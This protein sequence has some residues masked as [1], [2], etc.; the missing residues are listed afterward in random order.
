MKKWF[1]A[2]LIWVFSISLTSYAQNQVGA[3]TVHS[4]YSTINDI[5]IDD[6]TIYAATLGGLF[7]VNGGEVLNTY[8]TI[9]GMSRLDPSKL[10]L[11]EL[12]GEVILAYTDGTLNVFDTNSQTFTSIEDIQR[13]QEFNLKKINDL[14]TIGRQLFVATDFGIVVFGLDNYLVRNS[15]LKLGSFSR[16]V[17]INAIDI[18]SDSIYCATSSGVAIASLNDNLVEEDAWLNFENVTGIPGAMI[19][20]IVRFNNQIYAISDGN[21]YVLNNGIWQ[22][23][24]EFGSGEIIGFEKGIDELA[25]FLTDKVIL[26]DLNGN[27]AEI[28][29][30]TGSTLRSFE[31]KEETLH[32]G[33]LYNGIYELD[34]SNGNVNGQLLPEGPFIN[35]FSN[36][37]FSD[38]QLI[39]STSEAF[40]SLGDPFTRLRSYSILENEKW[41]NFNRQNSSE[42]INFWDAYTVTQTESDFFIGSWGKGIVRHH[43]ES[44]T[45]TLYNASNTGLTGITGNRDFLVVTGLDDD[46]NG[47]VWAVVFDSDNPLNKYDTED[48]QWS[49]FYKE[50][51]GTSNLYFDLFIDSNDLKWITIKTFGG[52]GT[53]LVVIDTKDPENPNDDE[54]KRL[55]SGVNSG[56]LPDDGVKAVIEDKDGEVWI[57]TERGI[58]RFLFPEFIVESSNPNEYR[59]Q[60]LINEDTSVVSRFLLR[61]VNVSAMAVNSANE[62]WIGSENQGL[63]VLN[64]EGSKILHRFTKEN[65]P[66]IS[67]NINSISINEDNG[68]VF[69]STD[70]GLVSYQDIP[71]QSRNKMKDLKVYPNPFIYDDHSQVLIDGLSDATDI[72]V[73]SVDGTIVNEFSAR[74]GRISW[75][76]LDYQGRKLGSGVY[77]IVALDNNGSEKGLG[78]IVIIN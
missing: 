50:N 10:A 39:T 48:D 31:I 52:T 32:V 36:L 17:Q 6:D 78:K 60:W 57:G 64:E 20:D 2:F 66:L 16:G 33:T 49:H 4:S 58:G 41:S 38:D 54:F 15:F 34:K 73:L 72:K 75:D 63:W 67:N 27:N 71:N 42:L 46:S 65:S 29:I 76:G 59:A 13:V 77:V 14:V 55:T 7:V 25:I 23:T 1:P 69:I 12:S 45:I 61:D 37:D 28:N 26:H 30:P 22:I 56:N 44:N 62:K 24:S 9:D 35:F 11:N 53:G 3:W 43:K 40:P 18:S 51:I 70:L 19:T 8:S 74:G 68:E 5:I 21:S 47:N